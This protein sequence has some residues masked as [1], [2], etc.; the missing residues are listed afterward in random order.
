MLVITAAEMFDGVGNECIFDVLD[1]KFGA[2]NLPKSNCLPWALALNP[3]TLLQVY[4]DGR[5]V[6]L[7][8][9]GT[10]STASDVELF[11]KRQFAA[12]E[13]TLTEYRA[14]ACSSLIRVRYLAPGPHVKSRD[15]SSVF[16]SGE[17]LLRM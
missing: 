11:I 1:Q 4:A 14:R 8:G 9:T 2:K 17:V 16:R 7:L 6:V 15:R 10:V 5:V 3:G 13:M 12:E